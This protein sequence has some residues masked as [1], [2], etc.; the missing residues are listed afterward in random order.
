MK[1][2]TRMAKSVCRDDRDAGNGAAKS[3]PRM[4]LPDA[5]G[6]CEQGFDLTSFSSLMASLL[7]LWVAYAL[8]PL[9]IV[10]REAIFHANPLSIL[11]EARKSTMKMLFWHYVPSSTF[12]SCIFSLHE[13]FQEVQVRS[14]LDR[15]SQRFPRTVT[16][17]LDRLP[18]M[19]GVRS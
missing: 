6:A 19:A 17:R 13:K 4:G 16:S 9:D 2:N 8:R 15:W 7:S 18:Q 1:L 3:W 12:I 10:G 14:F 11:K 5:V